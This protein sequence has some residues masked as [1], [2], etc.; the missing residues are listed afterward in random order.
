MYVVVGRRLE[1]RAADA[2]AGGPRAPG[3]ALCSRL[4]TP[5]RRALSQTRAAASALLRSLSY[6]IYKNILSLLGL[7]NAHDAT[8]L[9]AKCCL[10]VFTRKWFVWHRGRGRVWWGAGGGC[11]E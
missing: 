11:M 3:P 8:A 1:Q 7:N 9:G 5:R 10:G 2:P 6:K 4:S